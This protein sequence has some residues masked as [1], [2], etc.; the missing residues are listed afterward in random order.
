[1][2]KF[3]FKHIFL[4]FFVQIC[5]KYFFSNTSCNIF[6]N[7]VNIILKMHIFFFKLKYFSK[8]ILL[9]PR[10]ALK[11]GYSNII[12]R[13]NTHAF[14]LQLETPVMSVETRAEIRA[15]PQPPKK[16]K[17]KT[18]QIAA[19]MPSPRFR[20][21]IPFIQDDVILGVQLRLPP[22]TIIRFKSVRKYHVSHEVELMHLKKLCGTMDFWTSAPL[23]YDSLILVNTPKQCKLIC[24]PATGEGRVPRP[25]TWERG[26][27]RRLTVGDRVRSQPQEVQGGQIL[28]SEGADIRSAG[29]RCSLLAPIPT[30][31]REPPTIR[32]T[33]SLGRPW[34]TSKAL[35][36]TLR[37]SSVQLGRRKV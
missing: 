13:S 10:G 37:V 25:A 7:F 2:I 26:H 9:R 23:H 20:A 31:G 35:G 16:T 28:L 32:R 17:T 6:S 12:Y 33:T 36:A 21:L 29:L 8:Y 11:G 18:I 14:N 22:R 27:A 30:C 19:I 3:F 24:N 15:C 34:S 5:V 1:M 4:N